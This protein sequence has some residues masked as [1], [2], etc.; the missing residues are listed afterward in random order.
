[1]GKYVSLESA[2]ENLEQLLRELEN[3]EEFVITKNGDPVARLTT[4]ESLKIDELSAVVSGIQKR[5]KSRPL[6]PVGYERISISDLLRG[7][8]R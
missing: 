2:S 3:G 7:D 4:F 6:N 5:R 1:M 8:R